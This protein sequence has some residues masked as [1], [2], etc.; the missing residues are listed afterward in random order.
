MMLKAT[1]LRKK[2]S[3]PSSKPGIYS[4][5]CFETKSFSPPEFLL[6]FLQNFQV[7]FIWSAFSSFFSLLLEL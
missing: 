7:H 5:L 6:L 3:M 1:F 4:C 2:W